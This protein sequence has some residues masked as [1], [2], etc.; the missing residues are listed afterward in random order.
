MRS[1]PVE[2]RKTWRR[3]WELLFSLAMVHKIPRNNSDHN[4]LVIKLNNE[5]VKSI[6]IFLEK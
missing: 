4:P 6:R 1:V 2:V 5:H 3:S